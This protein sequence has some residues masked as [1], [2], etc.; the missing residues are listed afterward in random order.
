MKELWVEKYRP[1]TI[2]DYVFIDQNMKNQ[3]IQWIAD[4]TIPTLLLAG[5]AG[6]GKTSFIFMIMREMNVHPS[7]IKVVNASLSTGIETIRE[8]ILTFI[9]TFG[10]GDFRYVILDEA[11]RLSPNAQDSLKSMIEEYS[12]VARFCLTT[13][14]PNKITPPIKSRCQEFYFKQM[15]EVEY[16]TRAAQ[17]LI[18]EGIEFDLDTLDDFARSAYPDLR[19][20]INLLQQHCTTGVLTKKAESAQTDGVFDYMVDAIALIKQDKLYDARKIICTNIRVEDYDS[21]F[22]QLYRNL[23]LW[24]TTDDQQDAAI[25]IIRDGMIKHT[26]AADPEINLSATITRLIRETR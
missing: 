17:I 20:L 14:H 24:G 25:E 4:N 10:S 3:T 2:N 21:I 26:L 22:T 19:K 7:D 9:R 23:D 12:S 13:N 18:E 6:L 16:K 5:S 1:K 11:D 15:D 8:D